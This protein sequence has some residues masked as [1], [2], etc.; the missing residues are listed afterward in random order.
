[1]TAPAFETMPRSLKAPLIL[2]LG[3]SAT[4][5]CAIILGL[6]G[7][8]SIFATPSNYSNGPILSELEEVAPF[9]VYFTNTDLEGFR[10]G[11]DE[12]LVDSINQ[13]RLSVDIAAYDLNLWGVRDALIAAHDRGVTVRLVTE[14]DNLENPEVQQLIEEGIPV[15]DDRGDGLMHN[16]FAI[17]DRQEVWSGSMNFTLNGAY[18]NDNNLIRVRDSQ[19]AAIY[20]DE[21]EEMFADHQ[22]GSISSRETPQNR[23]TVDE[24][25]VEVYFSPDDGVARHLVD[26]V[27]SAQESIHILAFNLT[28]DELAE[29]IVDRAR[30]GV[31]V[32]GVFDESQANN[33]GGE[34]QTLQAAGIE[35]LLDG[36]RNKMHHKVIII[37]ES[38]VITGSYNF[39][40]SAET[41]NDE[42]VLILYRKDIA[43]VYLEEFTRVYDQAQK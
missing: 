9:Q 15:V 7:P 17:I 29:A 3:L 19:V 26:L 16:K 27:Q 12:A 13:A 34:F 37:D 38:I 22:F 5:V 32:T 43:A 6:L 35:V 18:R 36:N 33:T 25:M 4:I 28:S 20:L 21:F 1:V 39:S 8:G 11:P 30:A 31:I 14:T 24:S 10:G 2:L 42:N 23:F 40:K 41:F